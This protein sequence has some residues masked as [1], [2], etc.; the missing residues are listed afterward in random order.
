MQI[1]ERVDVGRRGNRQ[2][3]RASN[4]IGKWKLSE[5]NPALEC[6][7]SYADQLYVQSS[8][9]YWTQLILG[10]NITR[11][12]I[13]GKIGLHYFF[14]PFGRNLASSSTRV[15]PGIAQYK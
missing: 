6:I 8:N 4:G 3:Q 2:A 15:H 9:T 12:L 1:R 5:E 14:L 7:A 10:Q 11:Q 13:F